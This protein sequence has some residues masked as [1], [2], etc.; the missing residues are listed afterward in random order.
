VQSSE[1]PSP[2]VATSTLPTSPE[3]SHTAFNPSSPTNHPTSPESG[4]GVRPT[5]DE[6][7]TGTLHPVEARSDGAND[8]RPDPVPVPITPV[9]PVVEEL[10][11]CKP[12]VV[13]RSEGEPQCNTMRRIIRKMGLPEFSRTPSFIFSIPAVASSDDGFLGKRKR[14]RED[15]RDDGLPVFLPRLVA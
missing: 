11:P 13:A 8:D 3:P 10:E 6:A 14:N 12:A 1:N 9:N 5:K 15:D 4:F 2:T 7:P